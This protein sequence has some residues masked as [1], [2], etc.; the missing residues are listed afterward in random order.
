M[1]MN[2]GETMKT[3]EE[4][5]FMMEE[6]HDISMNPSNEGQYLNFNNNSINNADGIDEPLDY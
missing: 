5:A 2:E 3:E 6:D 4:V 1:M